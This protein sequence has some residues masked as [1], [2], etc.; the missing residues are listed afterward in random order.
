MPIKSGDNIPSATVMKIGAEGP[1]KIDTAEFFAGKKV[2]LFG[3]PGAFTPTCSAR[4]LPGFVE[5]ADEIKAKGVDLIACMSVNDAFVMSEWGKDQNVE[6]KVVL[7]ADGN[8]DFTR[9]LDLVM[10]GKGFCMGER[11]QRFSMVIENGQVSQVNVEE[12]GE[13]KV[14]S[15]EYILDQI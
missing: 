15:S 3:L 6:D 13:Y 8:C 4:H 14:S 12:G 7:L 5:K 10:D 1:E 11:C 9:A 2:V